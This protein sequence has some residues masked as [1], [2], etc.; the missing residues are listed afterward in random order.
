MAIL[1]ETK[2]QP[3]EEEPRVV[4]DPKEIIINDLKDQIRNIEKS[5]NLRDSR[6]MTRA[7]R[8][9]ITIRKKLSD[10]ILTSIISYLN[11]NSKETIDT[12]IGNDDME[13]D[14]LLSDSIKINKIKGNVIPEIHIYTHLL[15]L[16]HLIDNK[17]FKK[18]KCCADNMMEKLIS[19]N[20]RTLDLLAAKCYFYYARIYEL[21]NQ[22]DQIRRFLLARFR[23]CTLRKD[24]D[25]LAVLINLILRNYLLYKLYNQADIFAAKTNFPETANNNEW[26]RY[27]YYIGHIK[28]IHLEYSVAQKNLLQASRKGPQLLAIGFKQAINK[29][30]IVVQLLLGEIPERNL[31]KDPSLKKS[32]LPYFQLT[33]AVRLGDIEFFSNVLQKYESKFLADSTYT[34]IIRLR[35]NVLKTG[36]KKINCAYSRV[37]LPDIAAKLNLKTAKNSVGDCEYILA[38]AIRD[39]VIEASVQHNDNGKEKTGGVYLVNGKYAALGDQAGKEAMDRKDYFNDTYG[40][41]G[42]GA[43]EE[44]CKIFHERINFCLDIHERCVKSLRYPP[45]NYDDNE[46][47]EG[48]REKEQMDIEIAKQLAET[49]DDDFF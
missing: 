40:T 4:L 22:A 31:F 15:V 43:E 45:K 18:G 39:K 17:D 9:L 7:L 35:R 41:L 13:V 36:I 1:I 11:P 49:D 20:R 5:V 23:T 32:L 47:N 48:R 46:T 27:Y 24:N 42:E 25:G 26:A 37:S 10:D 12:F 30:A 6:Y 2:T 16:L 3:K 44:P 38:K 14:A 8:S 21:N 28:A 34:L 29:L 19:Q 33:Q